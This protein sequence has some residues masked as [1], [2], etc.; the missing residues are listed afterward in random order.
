MPANAYPSIGSAS[1]VNTSMSQ[2]ITG[3]KTFLAGS[4][5]TVPVTIQATPGQT[6]NLTEWRDSA[7]VLTGFYR[8]GGVFHLGTAL[9]GGTALAVNLDY[10]GATT[11]GIRVRGAAS[12]TASLQEWQN[13]AGTVLS[14]VNSSGQ[15]HAG[16]TAANIG[17]NSFGPAWDTAAVLNASPYDSSWKGLVV[18]GAASQSN[19]LTEWQNSAATVVAQV[20]PAGR[21]RSSGL[22]TGNMTQ[23]QG[24]SGGIG[25]IATFGTTLTSQPNVVV[26]GITSQTANLT[27]WQNNSGGL[28]MAINSAGRMAFNSTNGGIVGT[29]GAASTR[30][31]SIPVDFNGTTRWIA[32]YDTS[33]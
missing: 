24:Q 21:L 29:V 1:Y 15:L 7:G 11:T 32:V 26:M 22:I 19:N 23:T 3:A 28:L 16:V 9:I 6:S 20:E 33:G 2:T 14:Y 27:E 4:T 25:A 8:A 17:S 12:Q 31:G 5:T 13:S 30:V 10:Q 18:R